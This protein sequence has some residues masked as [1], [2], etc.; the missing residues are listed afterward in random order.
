MAKKT[1]PCQSD[2]PF[3]VEHRQV[4][5]AVERNFN[6]MKAREACSGSNKRHKLS[7]RFL[8]PSI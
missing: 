3:R 8:I 2:K 1:T 4:S 5:F 7:P 6:F